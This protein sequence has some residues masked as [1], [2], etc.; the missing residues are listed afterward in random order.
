MNKA[1]VMERLRYINHA[2]N[3]ILNAREEHTT[4]EVRERMVE[5]CIA[6][7]RNLQI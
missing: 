5:L 7:M 3:E 4:Q 6:I 1:T 2:M